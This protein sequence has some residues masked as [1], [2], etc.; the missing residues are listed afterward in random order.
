MPEEQEIGKSE[1]TDWVHLSIF[2][3]E[4]FNGLCICNISLFSHFLLSGF[5]AQNV[6]YRMLVVYSADLTDR[7]TDVHINWGVG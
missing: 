4:G 3:H 7:E 6:Y 1:L 5:Q 2:S